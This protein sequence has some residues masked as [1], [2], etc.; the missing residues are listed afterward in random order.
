M[1]TLI[2]NRHAKSDWSSGAET[3]FDR[4]LNKR[5]NSDAPMMADRLLERNIMPD[6][7]IS[8]PAM[9]AIST[10]KVFANKLGIDDIKEEIEIYNG[11][12]NYFRHLFPSKDFS[13]NTILAFGHNP[14]F[15]SLSTY[16]SGEYFGNVP[17]CGIVCIDFE[18]NTWQDINKQN[19]KLRFFDY[20]KSLN[21]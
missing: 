16:F 8:S 9:R 18:I 14:D 21:D 11:G 15:T 1:K 13:A 12:E 19:G 6:I 3:D 10:A 5:G 20:P 7:I 4:P 2:L 17:T